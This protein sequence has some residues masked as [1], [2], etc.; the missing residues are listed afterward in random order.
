MADLDA[1]A[2]PSSFDV[3]IKELRELRHAEG[4]PPFAEIARRISSIR[5]TRGLAPTAARIAR[6][7]VFDAFRTG[8]RVL[9]E[10]LVRD[11]TLA[12]GASERQAQ[13]WFDRCVAAR[14]ALRQQGA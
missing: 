2:V 11:I 5:Q 7:T 3:I 9:D 6:S 12:L 1:N 8:R 4:E 13:Q 14:R 10:N